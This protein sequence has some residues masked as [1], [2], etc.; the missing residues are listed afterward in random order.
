M[1]SRV[2]SDTCLNITYNTNEYNKIYKHEISRRLEHAYFINAAFQ[3]GHGM[4]FS[5][6]QIDIVCSFE[7]SL[8]RKENP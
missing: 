7:A 2:G 1:D 4:D 5:D 3:K 8:E 6:G